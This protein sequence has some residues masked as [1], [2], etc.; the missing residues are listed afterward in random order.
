MG[1]ML[2][3]RSTA[4]V[5]GTIV[6]PDGEIRSLE[7]PMSAAELMFEHPHHFVVELGSRVSLPLPAD[8]KLEAR[9]AY[10]VL[11]MARG[12]SIAR[13]Q[14]F[15]IST[16]DESSY[17]DLVGQ[18]AVILRRQY[19]SKG[20]KPGLGTIAERLEKKIPHWLF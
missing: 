16:K 13:S 18:P 4:D 19:S 7:I 1:N 17:E 3:C 8:H 11:P 14:S 2:S 6:L 9:K 5:T 12:K 15:P 10:A 20:W